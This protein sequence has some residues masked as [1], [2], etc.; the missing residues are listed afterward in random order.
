MGKHIVKRARQYLGCLAV[1]VLMLAGAASHAAE[2]PAKAD[3]ATPYN[4]LLA[5]YVYDS[6]K[7]G[8][9]A[10]LVDY[11][12]WAADKNHAEAMKQLA[13]VNPEKLAGNAEK[14]FWIN[15][16]NLLTIDLIVQNEQRQTIRNV[17]S[18]LDD[19]WKTFTWQL[20][21][22]PVTLDAIMNER[23]PIHQDVRLHMALANGTLSGADLLGTAYAAEA[24]DAQLDAQVRKFLNNKSKGL[25]IRRTVLEVSKMFQKTGTDFELQGGIV[26]FLR[27]YHPATPAN[28]VV[29]GYFDYNW[30]LNGDW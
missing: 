15:A 13:L 29:Q 7:N 9:H 8:V 30:E 24:L 3:Y 17:G 26:A 21:G 28:G 25:R 23:L 18:V 22:K 27:K 11:K 16:Y 14:A 12:S 6:D 20:N 1:A 2:A 19:P 10:S 4:A 5:A